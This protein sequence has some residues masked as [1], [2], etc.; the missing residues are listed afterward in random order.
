MKTNQPL[1]ARQQTQFEKLFFEKFI[2]NK[3]YISHG[4]DYSGLRRV[5]IIQFLWE[6]ISGMINL[7]SSSIL[8]KDNNL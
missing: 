8:W 4:I 6:S 3:V 5:R 1:K 7:W 2:R